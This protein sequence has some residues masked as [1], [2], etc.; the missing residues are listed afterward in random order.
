MEA[1]AWF[2]TGNSEF[3]VKDRMREDEEGCLGNEGVLFSFLSPETVEQTFNICALLYN[4]LD[5]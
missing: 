3:T 5:N 4:F 2:V 1:L